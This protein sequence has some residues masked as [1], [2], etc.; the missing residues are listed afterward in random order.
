MNPSFKIINVIVR[1]IY[2][3]HSYPSPL[4]S[5][6]HLL[7]YTS[8]PIASGREPGGVDVADDRGT[9]QTTRR[10]VQSRR[11]QTQAEEKNRQKQRLRPKL[12][13]VKG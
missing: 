8:L 10:S 9:E 3:P 13:D 11:Q 12:Q 4:T 5:S 7:P 1:E 6:P 2:P